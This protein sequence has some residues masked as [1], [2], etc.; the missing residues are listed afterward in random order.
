MQGWL[1][2]DFGLILMILIHPSITF[3]DSREG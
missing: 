1:L 3:R 2:D